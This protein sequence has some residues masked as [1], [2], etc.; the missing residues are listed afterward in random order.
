MTTLLILLLVQ[1]LLA[2]G[3]VFVLK[4]ILDRELI[5]VALENL[6]ACKTSPDVKEIIVRLP[7]AVSDE[8]KSHLESIRKRKFIQA[9]LNI[10][11]DRALKGGMVIAVG[12]VLLD[13]SL[14]SRL[15]HFWS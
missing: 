12:D 8:I 9:N 15:Q 10:Q 3:V 11:E 4:K 14:S 6:E 13:F 2:I 7:S 5:E 1:C